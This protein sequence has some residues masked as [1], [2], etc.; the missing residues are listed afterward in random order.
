MSR[1][2]HHNLVMLVIKDLISTP[3][4]SNLIVTI[5]LQWNNLFPMQTTLFNQT[6]DQNISSSNDFL[7]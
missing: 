3:L 2:V 1:N 6:N 7:F 4:Y 5:H